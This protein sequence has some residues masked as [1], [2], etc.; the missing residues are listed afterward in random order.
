MKKEYHKWSDL[1]DDNG[2]DNNHDD[3]GDD[4]GDSNKGFA[5]NHGKKNS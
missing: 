1:H 2:N 3:D 5:D 4:S